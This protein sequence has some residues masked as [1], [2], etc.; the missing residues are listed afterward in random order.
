MEELI[1]LE[2]SMMA[3]KSLQE[4]GLRYMSGLLIRN[5][6]LTDRGLRNTAS[7]L[8]VPKIKSSTVNQKSSSYRGAKILNS[9]ST[10][11]SE[12]SLRK[13]KCL[14]VSFLTSNF[15]SIHIWGRFSRSYFAIND[16]FVIKYACTL[17]IS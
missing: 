5:S 3:L 11:C 4:L 9:L 6:V 10:E 1:A 15:Y 13:L 14:S 8:R 16:S 2:S 17:R 7:D 12:V